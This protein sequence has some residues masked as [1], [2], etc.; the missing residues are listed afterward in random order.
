VHGGLLVCGGGR[1]HIGRGRC[2]TAMTDPD[3]RM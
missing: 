3:E 2:V 1:G